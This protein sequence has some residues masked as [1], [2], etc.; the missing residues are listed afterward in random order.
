MKLTTLDIDSC[1][2]AASCSIYLFKGLDAF[3]Q[4]HSQR[5][6]VGSDVISGVVV[7]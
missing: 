7:E 5:P 2:A 4:I 6:E 1:P 3:L